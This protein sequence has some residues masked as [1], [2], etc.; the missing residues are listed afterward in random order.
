[1]FI[2]TA[3]LGSTVEA[4]RVSV[5]AHQKHQQIQRSLSTTTTFLAS[6][7]KSTCNPGESPGIYTVVYEEAK[8]QTN[9]DTSFPQ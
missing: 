3:M 2:V 8:R 9:P 4:A 5:Y 6:T 7:C 1:M